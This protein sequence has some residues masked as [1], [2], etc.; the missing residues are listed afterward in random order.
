MVDN[1]NLWK[2]NIREDVFTNYFHS[3]AIAIRN[4]NGPSAALGFVEKARS[5]SANSDVTAWLSRSMLNELGRLDEAQAIHMAA[6]TADPRYE[7]S[8]LRRIIDIQAATNSIP[9]AA[10][11]RLFDQG[12]ATARD[13]R[14]AETM[15][16]LALQQATY[17]LMQNQQGTIKA[18]MLDEAARLIRPPG[19]LPENTR[20]DIVLAAIDLATAAA[21]ADKPDLGARA[22]RLLI[23][24]SVAKEVDAG[25]LSQFA[26][27]LIAASAQDHPEWPELRKN[28]LTLLERVEPVG[29]DV[30]GPLASFARQAFSS[31]AFELGEQGALR[32]LA[33]DPNDITLRHQLAKE[34]WVRGDHQGTVDIL[35]TG[36]RHLTLTAH[37]AL[38]LSLCGRKEEALQLARAALAEAP[39]DHLVQSRAGMALVANGCSAEL[40]EQLASTTVRADGAVIALA[41]A[42]HTLRR[43]DEALAWIDGLTGT[44]SSLAQ[45]IAQ[46]VKAVIL[47]DMGQ[48]KEAENLY[49]LAAKTAEPQEMLFQCQLRPTIAA[50]MIAG[51][52]RGGMVFVK[53]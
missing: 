25:H 4:I 35:K 1:I 19:M 33:I 10:T 37:L 51:L 46:A 41:L 15:L 13:H 23:A 50:Q 2:K 48:T 14:D 8:A 18:D 47:E 27:L 49:R 12:I 29:S 9:A 42:L 16:I 52:R 34:R 11:L 7:V 44:P 39:D 22:I 36:P 32:A 38:Y 45:A 26:R 6:L 21:R 17:C 53:P 24:A 5:F 28:L 40:V 30:F 43:F 20:Q 3:M 31:G